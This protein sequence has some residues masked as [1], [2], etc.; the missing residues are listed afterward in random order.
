[1]V[2][3]WVLKLTPWYDP[4]FLIP[5]AGMIFASAM[6]SVSLAGERFNA[7]IGRQVAYQQARN[8]ALHAALIPVINSLFAVG[9][10]SLPGMMTG[11]ILSGVDPAIAA[12]YQVMVMCMLFSAAGLSAICFLVLLKRNKLGRC[13]K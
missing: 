7:E 12:R 2:V 10:V 4:H 1:V 9:L 6:N 5:V 3:A 11:Q 13:I 8:R